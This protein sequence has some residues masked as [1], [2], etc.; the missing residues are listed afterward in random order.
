MPSETS[1]KWWVLVAIGVSTFMSALDSS[2]VNIILPVVNRDFNTS[3]A[4]IEWV[5]IIYLLIV[6]GLLLTFGRLGDL[7]GHRQIFLAGFIIFILTSMACGLAPP[8]P[9]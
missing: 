7:R 6:G 8:P 1:N 4:T 3:V 2:V 5:V 9:G